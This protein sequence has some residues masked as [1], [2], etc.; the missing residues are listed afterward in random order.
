MRATRVFRI[1]LTALA[2]V[3]GMVALMP[4]Q[5][6]AVPAAYTLQTGLA[7]GR[8][9]DANP[10][11]VNNNGGQIYQWAYNGGVQQFW[12]LYTDGTIRPK[13]NTNMCLDANP[14]TNWDGGTVYLWTCNGGNQQKWTYPTNGAGFSIKNVHSGRCLDVNPNTNYNGGTVYQWSC[15]TSAQQRWF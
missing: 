13:A 3:F 14:S 7:P 11:T 1:V 12:Y 2:A 15:N 5:A 10:A 8:V 9:L 6:S 4:A